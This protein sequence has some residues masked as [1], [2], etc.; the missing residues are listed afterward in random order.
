MNDPL[1]LLWAIATILVV[2]LG[3]GIFRTGQYMIRHWR[4]RPPF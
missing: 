1:I 3:Y 4:N 2:V